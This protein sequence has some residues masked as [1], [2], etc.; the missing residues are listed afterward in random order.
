[1]LLVNWWPRAGLLPRRV[2]LGAGS[3]RTRHLCACGGRLSPVQQQL[4]Q[5]WCSSQ[6]SWPWRGLWTVEVNR[7]VLGS[8][9]APSA[10]RSAVPSKS[11]L[12]LLAGCSKWVAGLAVCQST[13]IFTAGG[14]KMCSGSERGRRGQERQ[15]RNV[16]RPVHVSSH[17]RVGVWQAGR[18]EAV[19]G[20][21]KQIKK[22]CREGD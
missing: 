11:Q 13:R 20:A 3:S 6:C 14:V 5:P 7:A 4:L 16:C 18:W 12:Q 19:H 1:M 9:A 21:R 15:L 17:D 10:G 2:W 22:L 8:N